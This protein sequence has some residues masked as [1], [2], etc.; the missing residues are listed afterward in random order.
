MIIWRVKLPKDIPSS[1]EYP[2]KLL[3]LKYGP[4]MT[5]AN[6]YDNIDC[7]IENNN[8]HKPNMKITLL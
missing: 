1:T 4:S 2:P 8:K 3:T 5:E 7:I 6:V